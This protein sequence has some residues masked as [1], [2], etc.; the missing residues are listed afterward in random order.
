MFKV[1]AVDD[2]HVASAMMFP[3][4]HPANIAYIETNLYRYNENLNASALQFVQ[5]HN[6][7]YQQINHSDIARKV[8]QLTSRTSEIFD[9]NLIRPLETVEQFQGANPMEQRLIMASPYI[10][11]LYQSNKVEGFYDSYRDMEPGAIAES[12]NDYRAIWDGHVQ[13]VGDEM[14]IRHYSVDEYE[15]ALDLGSDQKFKAR[16]LQRVAEE[17]ARQGFDVTNIYGGEVG[18]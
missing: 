2:P 8:R 3:Q 13:E 18:K 5:Q 6:Q 11:G 15:G 9:L 7:V 14:V 17:L 12:H 1:M 4:Q 10:R 16:E